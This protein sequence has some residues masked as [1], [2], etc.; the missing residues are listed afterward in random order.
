MYKRLKSDIA[1]QLDVA[2]RVV[3][4]SLNG[5][6]WSTGEVF[7]GKQIQNNPWG[8]ISSTHLPG[9]RIQDYTLETGGSEV[10]IARYRFPRD[11]FLP[12]KVIAYPEVIYGNK[13]GTN[14]TDGDL[15]IL[16]EDVEHIFVDFS[17]QELTE[18]S[19]FDSNP[20]VTN[21][22]L[23]TFFMS[24]HPDPIVGP[25]HLDHDRND[26]Q[27]ELELMVWLKDPRHEDP[28]I[29]IV[30]GQLVGNINVVDHQTG[31]GNSFS[32]Y[33]NGPAYVAFIADSP[34]HAGRICWSDLMKACVDRAAEWDL[35]DIDPKWR[36]GAMEFGSEIWTG[37]GA[38]IADRFGVDV[39]VKTDI[40]DPVI[41]NTVYSRLAN[42]HLELAELYQEM[43]EG[44]K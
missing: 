28:D 14:V 23:E 39:E 6:A 33:R 7:D 13:F 27:V 38:W 22:A 29:G 42:C 21:V 41:P 32:V 8:A 31:Q 35:V 24:G 34:I 26:S 16:V 37:V 5:R 25:G 9:G 40:Q 19:D 43:A 36:I 11:R 18:Y 44:S 4:E 15:P 17:W 1:T 2:D 20:G 3:S 30:P 10:A 12:G